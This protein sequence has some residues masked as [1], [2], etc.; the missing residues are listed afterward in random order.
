MVVQA[1]GKGFGERTMDEQVLAELFLI[2]F[3]LT[4]C[5]VDQKL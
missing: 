4:N 1:K 2:A 5:L 3:R